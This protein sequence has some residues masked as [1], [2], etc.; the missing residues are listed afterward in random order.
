LHTNDSASAI[1][2]LLDMGIAPYKIAAALAGVVAQRLIRTLCKNCQMMYYP[3]QEYLQM[4]RYQGDSRRQFVRAEGCSACSHTGFRGRLG[5]FEI[6]LVDREFRELI[7]TGSNL[8]ALRS[9][10][11]HAGGTT[12]LAEGIRVAEEGKTSLEEVARVALFE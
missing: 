12:L 10:H 2:R 7:C 5:L 3:P 1:T 9:R 8:D 6:L 4:L 11:Q